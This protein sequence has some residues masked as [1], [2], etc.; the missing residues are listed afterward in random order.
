[1]TI[2]GMNFARIVNGKFVE[3]WDNWDAL[4]MMQQPGMPPSQAAELAA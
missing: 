1:M 4:G 2:T 3:S